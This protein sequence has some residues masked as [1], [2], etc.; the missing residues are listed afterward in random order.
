MSVRGCY[1][2]LYGLFGP[3]PKACLITS[4]FEGSYLYN[5]SSTL[6]DSA[7]LDDGPECYFH[8]KAR[9]RRDKYTNNTKLFLAVLSCGCIAVF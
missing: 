2:S 5:R 7:S 3:S 1:I 8:T 6:V 4:V 9:Q